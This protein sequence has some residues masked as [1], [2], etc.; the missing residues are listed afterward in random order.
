LV[1]IAESSFI[2]VVNLYGFTGA[3]PGKASEE[4][5]RATYN[6]GLVTSQG[7]TFT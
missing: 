2:V 6:A 5:D 1:F 4:A 3:V 7:G